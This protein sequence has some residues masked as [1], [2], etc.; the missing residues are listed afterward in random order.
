MGEGFDRLIGWLVGWLLI[1]W[2]VDWLAW[3]LGESGERETPENGYLGMIQ[4]TLLYLRARNS[5]FLQK[6]GK[7]KERKEVIR[8]P[9]VPMPPFINRPVRR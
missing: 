6:K 1:G 7:E 8:I 3:P 9:Y 5:L 2:L 4:R